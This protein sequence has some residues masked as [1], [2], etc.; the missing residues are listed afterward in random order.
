MENP[1]I[2]FKVAEARRNELMKEAEN[3][4]LALQAK[5]SRPSEPP[6]TWALVGITFAAVIIGLVV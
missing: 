3:Y 1:D 4:R 6:I 5:K 2:L